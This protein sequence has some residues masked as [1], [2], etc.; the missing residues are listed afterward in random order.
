MFDVVVIGLNEE[1]NLLK[2]IDSLKLSENHINRKIFI[3]S[4]STD[5]SL[6]VACHYFDSIY[7]IYNTNNI[8]ASL[9]RAIGAE[10]SQGSDWIIFLDADMTLNKEFL[11][12]IIENQY[13]KNKY[14]GFVGINKMYFN[15]KF[16][17]EIKREKS[18]GGAVI[19]NRN[20]LLESG[21]WSKYIFST[22]EKEL[23]FRLNEN[24]HTIKSLNKHM[25]S[26]YDSK[27]KTFKEKI[28]TLYV[29]VNKKN[30]IGLYQS[31]F[32]KSLK[33][34]LKL[35]LSY[36]EIRSILYLTGLLLIPSKYFRILI[37]ILQVNKIKTNILGAGY[38]LK[39]LLSRF[40]TSQA[41]IIQDINTNTKV[42]RIK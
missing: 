40:F 4:N 41:K 34:K 24:N 18:F 3:D 16:S 21:N 14:S 42:E 19:L 5:N 22:E 28:L 6:N 30:Y 31:L 25:I 7:R 32:H 17:H 2:C 20:D 39:I 26:H 29:P 36:E 33:D 35:L 10:K 12:N 8:S 27:K 23:L 9:A 13:Y 37:L 1:E 15:N 11:E 38:L